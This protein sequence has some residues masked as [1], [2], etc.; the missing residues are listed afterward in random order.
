M[1]SV[2]KN[3]FDIVS[4]K[5]NEIVN[6]NNFKNVLEI[7]GGSL[8]LASKILENQDIDKYIVYEKNSSKYHT[9]D[10]RLKLYKEYFTKDTKINEEIDVVLHSHVLEHTLTPVDFI[11]GIKKLRPKYHIIV[12]PNLYLQFQRKYTNSFNFEHNILITE[13]HIDV[14]LNNNNFEIMSKQYYLDHS[15]IYVTK[16]ND[17]EVQMEPYPNLYQEYNCLSQITFLFDN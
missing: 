8:L 11:N 5:V 15:I 14:L 16:Y 17:S 12:V 2:W 9:N 13:P 4:K 1:G 10:K 7:G 3:M 6:E